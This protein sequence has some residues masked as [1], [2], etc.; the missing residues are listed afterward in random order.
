MTRLACLLAVASAFTLPPLA[1][2]AAM[3][4]PETVY[5]RSADGTTEIVGYLFKPAGA[6]AHHAI[7]LLHGRGGPYSTNANSDCT[8]VG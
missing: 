3:A 2:T 6:G 7:V 1:A 4:P 8:F 5:F